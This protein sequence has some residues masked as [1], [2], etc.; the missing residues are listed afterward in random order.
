[1]ECRGIEHAAGNNIRGVSFSFYTQEQERKVSVKHV[2]RWVTF[3]RLGRP[4]RDGLHDPALGPIDVLERCETCAMSYD[5]CPGHYGHVELAL[6]SFHPLLFNQL[7]KLLRCC[8]FECSRLRMLSDD[9][10]FFARVLYLI[11]EG[12]LKEA[13]NMLASDAVVIDD[14]AVSAEA[15][16]P[17]GDYSFPSVA[18]TARTSK[19]QSKTCHQQEL[20]DRTVAGI[21]AAMPARCANCNAPAPS[22]KKDSHVRLLK[23]PLAKKLRGQA[24]PAGG[25]AAGTP[26]KKGTPKKSPQKAKGG[27]GMLSS[28]ESSDPEDDSEDDDKDEESDGDA[29]MSSTVTEKRAGVPESELPVNISPFKVRCVRFPCPARSSAQTDHRDKTLSGGVWRRDLPQA[30]V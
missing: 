22:L 18:Q 21:F 10:Q 5:D 16:D 15:R 6:P 27:G 19:Y 23:K 2:T 1:M 25:T 17:A 9:Q 24:A 11:K 7:Y 26:S 30:C 4:Q 8:C 29:V 13:S 28:D 12:Q 14:P 3:D 20:W